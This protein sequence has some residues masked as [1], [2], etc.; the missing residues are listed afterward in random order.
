MPAEGFEPHPETS[1]LVK[2]LRQSLGLLRVAFDATGEAMLIIDSGRQVR[3]VNQT[4]ADLWGGGLPLRVVG[5]PLEAL[6]RLRHLDQ[7]LLTLSDPHHPLN[8]AKLGEGQASLLVQAIVARAGDEPDVLQRMVSWRPISELG[9]VFTLLTFRDLEPLEKS[10]QQQRAFINNLAHELRTPLAILTGSL[11]RL[12]RK[13]EL[14]QPLER[15]LGD[16]IDETKRMAALVDKLLIL[17]ELDTDHFHWNLKRAPL[18][19]F[20][21]QWLHSLGPDKRAG[22]SLQINESLSTCLVDLDQVALSRI[23]DTLF[24]NSLIDGSE[25]FV[26]RVKECRLSEFVDIAVGFNSAEIACNQQLSRQGSRFRPGE[27]ELTQGGWSTCN[28][29]FSVVKNLVAGMGGMFLV[30]ASHVETS[31]HGYDSVTLRFPVVA[32]D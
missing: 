15:A 8:Q 32:P 3:W 31:T 9:G 19:D 18:R 6:L 17:S 20:L 30:H 13:S 25:G 2:Q 5:K 10:L 26:L 4:A 7:R 14:A 23:L 21:D 27:L 11:R 12:D 22:V 24:E 16:A 28:L 29:G 1:A